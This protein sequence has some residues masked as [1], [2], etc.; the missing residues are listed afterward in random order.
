MCIFVFGKFPKP[1]M[2]DCH[3]LTKTCATDPSV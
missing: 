1:K 2:I 3:S